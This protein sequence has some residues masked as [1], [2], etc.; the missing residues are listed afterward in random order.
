MVSKS[1]LFTQRDI[2]YPSQLGVNL[3]L[4]LMADPYGLIKIEML[5]EMYPNLRFKVD[6]PF[7]RIH[8]SI[9]LNIY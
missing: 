4:T 8:R 1:I 3:H 7:K 2:Y 6:D 9:G 5:K